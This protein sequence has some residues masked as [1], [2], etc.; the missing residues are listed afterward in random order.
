MAFCPN[1]SVEYRK[2]E[3]GIFHV[4]WG[5]LH[6]NYLDIEFAVKTFAKNPYLILTGDW[7]YD[8]SMLSSWDGKSQVVGDVHDG[9]ELL[10]IAKPNVYIR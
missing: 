2:R 6:P 8:V 9:K 5:F 10:I 4:N 3:P 7:N 1:G